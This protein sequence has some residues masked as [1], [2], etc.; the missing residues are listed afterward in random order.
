MLDFITKIFGG[1]KSEK[2]VK[3][4][5]PI[6]EQIKEEFAKLGQMKR[7]RFARQNRRI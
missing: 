2:D 3:A 5:M 4:I 1:G 6:V 7:C